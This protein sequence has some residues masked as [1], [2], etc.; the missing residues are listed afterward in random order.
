MDMA[1]EPHPRTGI[2]LK[3][4]KN[5]FGSKFHSLS[6]QNHFFQNG[7]YFRDC[8]PSEIYISQSF[9]YKC[10][11]LE[12]YI[13]LHIDIVLFTYFCLGIS[14]EHTL[15]VKYISCK[16]CIF[17]RSTGKHDICSAQKSGIV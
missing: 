9:L 5:I 7:Q 17:L 3:C 14:A 2:S 13:S 6:L 4:S 10:K 16:F 12:A 11:T 8:K 1:D 15:L